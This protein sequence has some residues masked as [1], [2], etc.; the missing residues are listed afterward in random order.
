MY[1]MPAIA[2]S[3]K[4]TVG[5]VVVNVMASQPICGGPEAGLGHIS[6][7]SPNFTH[8]AQT[9]EPILMIKKDIDALFNMN[10]EQFMEVRV[11]TWPNDRA[12]HV[13]PKNS[14]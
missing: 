8:T 13:P 12:N 11:T 14:I 1:D 10:S 2:L 5:C 9:T 3:C 6:N 4:G 7:P